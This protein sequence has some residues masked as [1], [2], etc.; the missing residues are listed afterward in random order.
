MPERGYPV[1]LYLAVRALRRGNRGTLLLTILLIALMVVLMNIMVVILGSVVSDYYQQLVD[2]QYGHVIILPKDKQTYI[3]D[4]GHLVERL[5]RVPGVFGV[6]SRYTTGVT[7]ASPRTGK[8]PSASLT[9]IDPEDEMTVSKYHTRII[10]GDYLAPGE[11]GQIV[12]GALLA[13]YEDETKDKFESLGGARVGDLVTVSYRNGAGK[14]YRVKGIYQTD[15]ALNDVS[16][17]V[18]RTDLESVMP[19]G[20]KAT[21]VVIRGN[22]GSTDP[23][24]AYSLKIACLES[25][26]QEQVKTWR[27]K[28]QALIADAMGSIQ[29]IQNLI[30]AVSL[31]VASVVVFVITFINITNRRKQIAIL[32]AI[33]IPGKTIVK[34]FLFQTF[35]LCSCGAFAGWLLLLMLTGLLNLFPLKM[36]TGY[37]YPS[38]DYSSF[39]I[40][41][42]LLYTVGLLSGYLPA[43]KVADED[44]LEAMR[45]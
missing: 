1:S 33:G 7:I 8:S 30:L 25:G 21:T 22:G 14:V 2:Y 32:K 42:L 13:G 18:T 43:R 23:A 41:I 39:F 5:E 17:F 10:D 11:T 20:G 45:G 35:F 4:A 26:V 36:N 12:I 3:A 9:A 16:A 44:I 34:N 31:V 38:I 15:T 6:S 27:E 29:L 40:S 37:V 24:Y 19:A 28:G